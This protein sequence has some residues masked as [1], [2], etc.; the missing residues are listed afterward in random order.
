[1]SI[2]IHNSENQMPA[3]PNLEVTDAARD[4]LQQ[5]E[6]YRSSAQQW[7]QNAAD[8]LSFLTPGGMWTAEQIKALK[9]RGQAPIEIPIIDPQIQLQMSQI[10]GTAPSF[11]VL[12][13]SDTDVEKAKLFSELCS[14]VWY[15][16]DAN[17]AVDEVVKHQLQVGKGYFYV[18]FDPNA[19]DGYGL[20][21][22]RSMQPF[23]VVPD[24]NSRQADEEDSICKFAWEYVT[25]ER[26]LQLFPQHAGLIEKLAPDRGEIKFV[27]QYASTQDVELY[28]NVAVNLENDTILYLIRQSKVQIKYIVVKYKDEQ[29]NIIERELSEDEFANFT[30]QVANDPNIGAMAENISGKEIYKLRVQQDVML[31]NQ[32]IATDILPTRY[33]TII[34]VAHTHNGNPYTVSLTRKMKGLQQEVNFRRSLM[35]AHATASTNAKVLLPIGSVA[36]P[37]KMEIDWAKPNALIEYDPTYGKPEIVQPIPLPNAHYTLEAMAKQDAEFIAGTF[38]L[39]HGDSSDA[40][41]TKGATQMLDHWSTRRIGVTTRA[42]YHAIN[43]LGKVIL[44]FIQAYM[45]EDRVIRIVNPYDPYEEEMT[46][47]GLGDVIG[48]ETIKHLGDPSVGQYDVVVQ[49][50]S[51]APT[52]RYLE[53][54]YYMGLVERGII[55]RTEVLKKVDLFDRKGVLERMDEVKNLTGQLQ[56]ANQ[57]I[58][59]LSAGVKRYEED[60]IRLRREAIAA[61]EQAKYTQLETDLKDNYNHKILRAEELINEL[62]LAKTA[63]KAGVKAKEPDTRTPARKE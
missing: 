43:I 11:R 57:M 10:I 59:D 32:I 21:V 50:G 24:P 29:G 12:P 1:M 30:E 18:Y 55:D 45:K 34:P 63:V 42:L 13:R 44:N 41:E 2:I 8:D 4:M 54:E 17:M 62:E 60:N 37:K 58:E 46:Q 40:P 35:I 31:G 38:R 56:Q 47:I 5:F 16:N 26:A 61:K 23:D 9:L 33:Y 48:D 7:Y 20:P 53:L 51:M 15:Q 27:S 22:I 14:Y 25:R 39:S 3:E 52:N 19:D 28:D 49:A 36:D 6:S